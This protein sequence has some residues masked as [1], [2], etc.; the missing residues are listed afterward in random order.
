MLEQ[1]EIKLRYMTCALLAEDVSALDE[2]CLNG[3]KE[4]Y[5]ALGVPPALA[6]RAVQIMRA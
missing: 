2:L 1:A 4:T 5:T 3:L 6:I